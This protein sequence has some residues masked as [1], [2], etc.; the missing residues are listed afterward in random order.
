MKA[1]IIFLIL[2]STAYASPFLSCDPQ[3][4]ITQ[5]ELR[6]KNTDN[7][8][9]AWETSAAQ[10]DTTAK[11]D[12]KNRLTGS[13]EIRA[14]RPVILNGVPQTNIMDCGPASPFAFSGEPIV[15]PSGKKLL[16]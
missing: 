7:T 2:A 13:G 12:L 9:G 11:H 6:W 4:G 5:Y 10:P 14:C 15:S 16:P 8:F 3:T 1:F